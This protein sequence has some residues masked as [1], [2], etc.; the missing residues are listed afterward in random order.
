M[1]R[2]TRILALLFAMA[3]VAS[4]CGSDSDD[5]A[6]EEEGAEELQGGGVDDSAAEEAL[7]GADDDDEEGEGEGEG[8]DE[9]SGLSL[10][11]ATSV[12]ELEAVWAE[13]RAA[14]VEMIKAEG[15]GIDENNVL[16]GPAGFTIDL[17]EC[18]ADWSDT[19]GLEDGK[20]KIGHTTAQSGNLAAYGDIAIGM[21]VYFDYINENGGIDGSLIEL[22]RKDDGY[23]STRTIELVDELLQSASRSTSRRSVRR[24]RLPPTT[25]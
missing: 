18:P 17:N 3:L 24:T 11:D 7:S 16:N 20:I 10:A 12:E 15:Y 9:E 25:S 6:T 13:E 1:N 14:I 19:E 8:E 22:S 2:M 5:T 4:A 21:D 23:E